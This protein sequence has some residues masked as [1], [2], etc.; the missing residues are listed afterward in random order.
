M[1]ILRK[2]AAF[3]GRENI[4]LKDGRLD[5]TEAEATRLKGLVGEENYQRVMAVALQ[6]AGGDPAAEL[7]ASLPAGITA[8][9][10]KADGS[11]DVSEVIRQMQ[12][13]IEVLSSEPDN[14]GG[15][16]I[17]AGK[18]VPINSGVSSASHLFGIEHDLF[19]RRK[20]W[21][22][23]AATRQPITQKWDRLETQLMGELTGYAQTLAERINNLTQSGEIENVMTAVD[24]SGFSG[25]GWGEQYITRRQDA[26]IGYLKNL[27]TVADIF[28]VQ[29]GVQDR[30]EM[31]NHFLSD[32]SQAYQKGEIWKG[33]HEVEPELAQVFDVMFKHQFTELKK[34]EREYLGYLNREG[35]SPIK[36]NFVEWLMVETLQKLHNEREERRVLGYRID[37]TENEPGHYMYAADGIVRKL[38]LYRESF[39]VQPF[40][41]FGM[42][43]QAD[44]LTYVEGFVE[45]VNKLVPSLRGHGLY[46][47]EKHIPWYLAAYRH[48]YGTDMDYKD[49]KLDV[50][51][52]QVD[53]IIGV[54]NMGNLQLMWITQVGNLE[55]YELQPGEMANFYFERRLENLIAA[56]WWKEGVG[57]YRSGRKYANA[58]AL[59][60]SKYKD[61]F[62]FLNH[63]VSELAAGATTVNGLLNDTFVTA[64]N[65]GA[66]AITDITNAKEGKVFK[67][68]C[69]SATNAT[70]IAKSGKFS[71]ITAHWVPTAV[72][73]FLE[74]YFVGGE[75]NKFIEVRRKVTA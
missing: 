56:S 66:T 74:V 25:S 7:L 48:Q 34:L 75:T 4:S 42:Y 53:H 50:K 30:Q 3:L 45:A 46:M 24:F 63:P 39:Q 33:K 62:I 55:L 5:V 31:T 44:I 51:S 43:T 2:L 32:F 54:P 73:D 1:K 20:P 10:K 26:M 11:V 71:E 21:N 12:A 37:P 61:Q 13:T 16:T 17:R 38:R 49:N 67:I 58:A 35:S 70:T 64:A 15:A 59:A 36:W 41:D 9:A 18:V 47:N 40:V 27:P 28:P 52:Y 14:A 69:G 65:A 72:G 29:Y 68:E 22:E 19:A 23:M 6:E 8:R 57:A 60:A